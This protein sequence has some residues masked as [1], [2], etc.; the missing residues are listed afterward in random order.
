MLGRETIPKAPLILQVALEWLTASKIW[1]L[2]RWSQM[3]YNCRG[4]WEGQSPAWHVPRKGGSRSQPTASTSC[5]S[6]FLNAG[7]VAAVL[8]LLNHTCS[9]KGE[10][11][12]LRRT[13][14]GGWVRE[15]NV[16]QQDPLNKYTLWHYSEVPAIQERLSL[17][18][19]EAVR[20]V[21]KKV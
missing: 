15:R 13:L 17:W 3:A 2:H 10:R 7:G 9:S 8:C 1:L 12:R 6:N 11:G 20:A 16:I 4:S 5:S 19:W 14:P 18:E 21:L